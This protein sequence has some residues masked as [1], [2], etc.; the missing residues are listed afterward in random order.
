MNLLWVFWL[1][2]DVHGICVINNT[3]KLYIDAYTEIICLHFSYRDVQK[4]IRQHRRS[5]TCSQK[6]IP[7]HDV[8]LCHNLLSLLIHQTH[9]NIFESVIIGIQTQQTKIIR[10]LKSEHQFCHKKYSCIRIA[11]KIILTK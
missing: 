2:N 9:L 5:I 4:K 11:T 6:V 1:K 7:Q 3:T 10:N 8:F